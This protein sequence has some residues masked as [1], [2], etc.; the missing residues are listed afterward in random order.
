[1][2]KQ[3]KQI[4]ADGD[5]SHEIKRRLLFGRKAPTNLDSILKSRDIILPTKVPLVKAMVFL[6]VMCWCESWT[7]K[8]AERWIDA[9]NCGVGED[10][11]ESLDSKEF[12]Q[13]NPKEIN[14]EYSLEGVM[15]KLKLQFSGH[16][17]WRANSLVRPWCWERLKAGWEGVDRGRDGWMASL[18]Q[19]TRIGVNSGSWWWRGRPGILQAMGSQRVGHIERLNHGTRTAVCLPRGDSLTGGNEPTWK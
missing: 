12:K 5:Y 11:W 15:L 19:W 2:G 9:L 1:M 16:L 13:V 14:P 6:V 8:K 4:T 7:I 17:I 3:W 10:S 18:T